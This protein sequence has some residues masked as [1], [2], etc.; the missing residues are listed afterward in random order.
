VTDAGICLTQII[1]Y[2]SN[3]R[4][5][6]S[7]SHYVVARKQGEGALLTLYSCCYHGKE[8]IINGDTI[9]E[10]AKNQWYISSKYI[11]EKD[12]CIVGKIIL[13]KVDGEAPPYLVSEKLP[14]LRSLELSKITYFVTEVLDIPQNQQ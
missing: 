8:L 7:L 14:N 3:K 5:N 10:T 13:D 11:I 1:H 9:K 6:S 2:D 4:I 12:S